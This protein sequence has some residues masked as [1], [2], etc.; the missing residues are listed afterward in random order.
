ML[1]FVCNAKEKSMGSKT[2]KSWGSEALKFSLMWECHPHTTRYNTT[3]R[4]FAVIVRP[5]KLALKLSEVMAPYFSVS[6]C[7]FHLFLVSYAAELVSSVYEQHFYK[8]SYCSTVTQQLP[9]PFLP[10]S[11]KDKAST[12]STTATVTVGKE[13]R[14][15]NSK[16]WRY[17]CLFPWLLVAHRFC[18]HPRIP[19][20]VQQRNY[21][22]LAIT[23]RFL[24]SLA[25]KS[26]WLEFVSF[27][28]IFSFLVIR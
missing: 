16:K 18:S 27:V 15:R 4:T 20:E 21:L 8:L 17:L 19:M 12:Q 2:W 7:V 10:I 22:D 25:I 3:V 6:T 28:L 24:V 23:L 11:S 9:Q 13:I 5:E 1:W 26:S 14:R